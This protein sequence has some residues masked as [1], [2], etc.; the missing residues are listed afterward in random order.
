MANLATVVM[1][2]CALTVAGAVVYRQV[3]PASA[4]TVKVRTVAD[5]ERYAAQGRRMGAEGTPVTIVE[6]SDYQCPFCAIA[7][8]SLSQLLAERPGE[9]SVVFRH[10]PLDGHDFARPAALAA[11][12]A[13]EQ[14]AF[15][16]FSDLLF[17]KQDSIGIVGWDAFAARAGVRDAAAFDRCVR[18]QAQR[19]RVDADLAA[20]RAL[21]LTGTP[22]FLVDGKLFKGA[23]SADSWKQVIDQILAERAKART[24]EG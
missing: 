6:F 1:V 16:P 14:G 10:F 12:C 7:H 8:K 19:A 13:A 9:V 18:G 5:W 2:L 22:T 11:E 3:T 24:P 15:Q 20:A 4:G 21:D 17:Q 23:L